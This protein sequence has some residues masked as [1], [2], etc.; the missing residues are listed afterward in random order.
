MENAL[1]RL[2]FSPSPSRNS[3]MKGSVDLPLM[4]VSNDPVMRVHAFGFLLIRE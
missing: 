2:V 3:V 4:A 1:S